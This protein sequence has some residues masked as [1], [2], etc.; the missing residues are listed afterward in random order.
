A[1][2]RAPAAAGGTRQLLSTRG[3]T[4]QVEGRLLW[5]SSE[6]EVHAGD[7]ILLLGANGAGKSSLLRLLARDAYH[8]SGDTGLVWNERVRV[9]HHDQV[10]RGL[11]DDQPLLG[12]LL[13]V[14]ST[15][16]SRQLL[17]LLRL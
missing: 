2:T 16:R 3:L 11:R 6:L 14:M 10:S 13:Q 1:R 12:Q 5:R 15:E 8:G 4:M 7:R 9:R 17:G